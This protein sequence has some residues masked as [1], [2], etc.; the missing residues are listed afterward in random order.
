MKKITL[1][2][3]SQAELLSKIRAALAGGLNPTLGILFCSVDLGITDTARALGEFAFP[4]FAC[5]SCGEIFTEGDQ[6]RALENS[7][8]VALLELP[9]DTFQVKLVDGTG[10]DSLALGATS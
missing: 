3:D 6:S 2:A 7:A 5:S 1:Q 4:F 10:L 9:A 8:V